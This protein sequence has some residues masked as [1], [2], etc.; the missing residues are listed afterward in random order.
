MCQRKLG[1]VSAFTIVELIAVIV[2]LIIVIGVLLPV[3]G[4]RSHI[5][6][7]QIKDGIQIR[8]IHQSMVTWAGQ[9]QDNYPIPSDIDLNDTIPGTDTQSP[10]TAMTKC[11]KDLPR[12]VMSL[13]MYNGSF[14]PEIAIS[15][16]EVNGLIKADP[17]FEFRNPSAVAPT[18]RAKAILDPAFACYPDEPGGDAPIPRSSG[19][20]GVGGFSYAIVPFVGA[21]RYLWQS[22]FDASQVVIGNRGPWYKLDSNGKWSL[23]PTDRRGKYNTP[24]TQS[25]TLLIHGART[26]WEGNVA[27]NDN[28][29]AFET[30]PD[31]ENLAIKYGA[32][33]AAAGIPQYDNIFANEDENG[34][35]KS[36]TRADD[37]I[38]PANFDKRKNNYLRCWGGDGKGSNLTIDPV[39]KQ[40]TSII[41]FWYD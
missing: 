9:N 21:R 19:T 26:S 4:R 35:G 34:D 8:S 18:K 29:V 37:R 5:N 6:Q 10:E 7:R 38:T 22:T 30:R 39:T 31:P 17:F 14:G 27:R 20:T 12:F 32:A 3:T 25:N 13:L 15:P 36:Y 40:I 11:G 1:Q 24:A 33:L 16:A 2:I 23:D 28:S 41:D